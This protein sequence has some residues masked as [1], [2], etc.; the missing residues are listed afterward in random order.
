[1]S[2]LEALAA[3]TSRPS[4][5]LVVDGALPPRHV[6]Q[7][8]LRLLSEGESEEWCSTFFMTLEPEGIVVGACG[9]KGP[10]SQGQVEVGYGVAPSMRKQGYASAALRSLLNIAFCSGEVTEV[11]AEVSPSNEASSRVVEKLGF[12]STGTRVDEEGEV[13][14]QWVA[15]SE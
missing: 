7:R 6:A 2:L 5:L 4:N 11:L 15:R 14:V 9:F 13:V 1:M 10:P 8:A 12:V 3:G